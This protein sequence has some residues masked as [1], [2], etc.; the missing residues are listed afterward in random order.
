[1]RC[2]MHVQVVC[3]W[4]L[5]TFVKILGKYLS[6]LDWITKEYPNMIFGKF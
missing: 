5:C 3:V 4:L 1:M 6:N 2:L